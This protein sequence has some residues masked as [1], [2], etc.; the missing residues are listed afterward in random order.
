M[1]TTTKT[2]CIGEETFH[3]IETE[4]AF[5]EWVES[6]ANGANVRE[7]YYQG[8]GWYTATFRKERCPHN[9]CDDYVITSWEASALYAER[10]EELREAMENLAGLEALLL[11]KPLMK[12]KPE[13]A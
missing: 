5:K 13:A 1:K 2:R 3:F 4:G 10:S 11:E 8:P 9:C 12:D 7:T 6:Q